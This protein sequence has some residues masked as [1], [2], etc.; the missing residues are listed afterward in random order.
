MKDVIDLACWL[1]GLFSVGNKMLWG[2][3]NLYATVLRRNFS[4]CTAVFDWFWIK[5]GC[6]SGDLSK[7]RA[8]LKFFGG[9]S[10]F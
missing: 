5:F 8:C 7:F 1:R 4:R 10:S 9:I 6:I 3:P 2:L